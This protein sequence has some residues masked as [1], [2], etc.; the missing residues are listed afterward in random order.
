MVESCGGKIVGINPLDRGRNLLAIY[1]N[2]VLLNILIID[3]APDGIR[4]Q[5]QMDE[6]HYVQVRIDSFWWGKSPLGRL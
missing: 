4:L 6:D 1:A 3:Q 2:P 5:A